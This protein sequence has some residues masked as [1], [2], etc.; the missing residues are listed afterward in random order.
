[1]NLDECALKLC[2]KNYLWLAL[3]DAYSHGVSSNSPFLSRCMNMHMHGMVVV[4]F[5]SS[6]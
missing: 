1:V 4:T 2:K 6:E 5:Y 3:M